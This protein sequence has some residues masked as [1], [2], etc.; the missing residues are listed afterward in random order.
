MKNPEAMIQLLENEKV[1]CLPLKACICV[2]WGHQEKLHLKNSHTQFECCCK[3][4]V[5]GNVYFV[6]F[7]KIIYIGENSTGGW[8]RMSGWMPSIL[9]DD[10]CWN[11]H[12]LCVFLE[13]KS[14]PHEKQNSWNSSYSVIN[15]WLSWQ[16]STISAW[17]LL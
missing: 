8:A 4:I 9:S 7:A 15:N 10:N 11:I 13:A 1:F 12:P 16:R 5:F 3:C 6:Y 17:L 2:K 14:H